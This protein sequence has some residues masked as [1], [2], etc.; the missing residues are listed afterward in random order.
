[1][2]SHDPLASTAQSLFPQEQFELAVPHCAA[3]E[4]P[5]GLARPHPSYRTCASCETLTSEEPEGD[6]QEG[7]YFHDAAHDARGRARARLQLKH[8]RR[9]LNRVEAPPHREMRTLELGCAKGFFVEA[10]LEAGI[11]AWGVDFSLPAI[12]AAAQRGLAKRCLLGEAGAPP[13]PELPQGFD[14]VCAW[15]VIEHLEQ[16]ELLLENALA[17]LRPG[18]W[19]VGSTPNADSTWA[20]RLG[21]GWHGYGIPQFHR[22]IFTGRGLE[23]LTRRSGFG[24]SAVIDTTEPG[25]ALLLKNRATTIARNRFGSDSRLLRAGLAAGLALPEWALEQATARLPGFGGD[26]LLFAAQKPID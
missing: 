18:G 10:A 24:R 21:R 17:H 14:L 9:L 8:V 25:G 1:M 4:T 3:C 26:T 11:D 20:K 5:L 19:L 7:Y 6:Y 15:E 23:R 13:P 22:L 16:P 2:K 12:T